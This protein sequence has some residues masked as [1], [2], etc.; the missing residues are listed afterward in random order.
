MHSTRVSAD[1][2]VLDIRDLGVCFATPGGEVEAVGALSLAI[3]PGECVGVVGESGAGKSQAFLAVMGLL[4]ANAR[5]RGSAR[6][7]GQELLGR[8]ARELNRVRGAGVAMIFQDP[9]TSLTPHLRIGA[10][11]AESLVR[12]TGASW[13]R[14]RARALELLERVQVTDPARRLTQYPHELSGGMRQRVMIAIALACGPKLLIADEPTTSLDVTI[15]AQILAL[16]AEL[17][18]EQGMSMVLITHDLGIVAGVADRVAVMQAGRLVELGSV[19]RI[20][21]HPEHAYTKALLHAIPWMRPPVAPATASSSSSI[22]RSPSPIDAAADGD[23]SNPERAPLL[24]LND[25]RVHF[26]L[27]G[28]WFQRASIIRALEAVSLTIHPGQ[29]VG[30]VG[31]SGS[32]KSTLARAALR[33]IRPASGHIVWL[34]NSFESLSAGELRPLRRDMQLV[35][36][37]PLASLDPRMTVADIVAEP[38]RVHRR[39]LDDATRRQVAAEILLR[40]G[41]GRNLLARYPHELSGGQAQRVAIARAMVLKPKLLVCD[42]AVSALDVSVQAQ[43][44]ALLQDLKREYQTAILFISHNLAVV[45]Q[46]CDRVL[47]LYLGRMMEEGATESLYSTPTHPYTR[48]LLAA[49]PVPDPDVQP[50]RLARVL[51]G[52]LPSPVA[53][54]SG[55]VFRTRCP[56]VKEVCREKIPEWEAVAAADTNVPGGTHFVA[57]HRWRELAGERD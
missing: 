24:A 48:G 9:L 42:E 36:Q 15:Q 49:V 51:G 45:R 43:I 17:K 27:R 22:R 19:D 41:L 10:Q 33:L 11:I 50:K 55:C 26:K 21:K 28:A 34:G 40:V 39:D 31:E 6:F 8:S 52:E 14:G 25:L 29:V 13:T 30:I 2:P 32:G 12:H 20:L 47:V 53:P 46:L 35:F 1:T 38:L 57:C 4:A 56:Y 16:L 7:A 37:D 23:S 3:Q 44:L 18:R 5:V 54:P